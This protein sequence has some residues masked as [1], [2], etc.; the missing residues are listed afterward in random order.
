MEFIKVMKKLLEKD[1]SQRPIR[2]EIENYP[3]LGL[4][5]NNSNDT[6]V[7]KPINTSSNSKY[8]S[9]GNNNENNTNDEVNDFSNAQLHKNK[10]SSSSSSILNNYLNNNNIKKI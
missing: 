1:P 7:I 6:N 3:F 8:Y 9:L 10:S 2:G 4:N 5:E